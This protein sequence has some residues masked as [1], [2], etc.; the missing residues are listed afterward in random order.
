MSE[1]TQLNCSLAA[2]MTQDLPF[3]ELDPEYLGSDSEEE[4]DG[5]QDEG[6]I[7]MQVL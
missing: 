6:D 3:Y 1:K 2:K 7:L 5:D 4:A